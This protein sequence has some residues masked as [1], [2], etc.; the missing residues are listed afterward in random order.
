MFLNLFI[1]AYHAMADK[2]DR[3][4]RVWAEVDSEDS[5]YIAIHFQDN[6]CGMSPEIMTKIF[7]YGF[8]T[9]TPGK[10]SGLGLYMCKYI[11]ELHGGA[12]KVKS[13]AGEG[14]T[15]SLML[16]VYEEVGTSRLEAQ[17]KQ[18]TGG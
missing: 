2:R 7:N 18:A 1:N 5:R 10:G 6:G 12:I 13:R 15:F 14:A 3:K 16:P 17:Q 8:T 9:K 11:L 4:I